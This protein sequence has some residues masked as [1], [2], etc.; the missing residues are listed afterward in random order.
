MKT[1]AVSLVLLILFIAAGCAK[2]AVEP[3]AIL[4]QGTDPPSNITTLQPTLTF[5][6]DGCI[7]NGPQEL[8]EKFD[9]TWTVEDLGRNEYFYFVVTLDEGKTLADLSSI[10]LKDN[11]PWVHAQRYGNTISPGTVT[12][13]IDLN[14]HASFEE[15]PIYFACAFSLDEGLEGAAGPIEIVK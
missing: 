3:T 11:D 12:K 1:K 13:T 2:P 10:T 6:E 8:P 5:G 7:Y 15:G 14:A 9:L 4:P